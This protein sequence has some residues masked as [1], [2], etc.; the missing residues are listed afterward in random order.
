MFITMLFR[1]PQNGQE[2]RYRA[3]PAVSGDPGLYLRDLFRQ[4][5]HTHHQSDVRLQGRQQSTLNFVATRIV[6]NLNVEAP[7][8]Y[9]SVNNVLCAIKRCS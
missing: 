7:Y 5:R 9:T 6:W 3:Q 4:D 8:V 2:E 1:N